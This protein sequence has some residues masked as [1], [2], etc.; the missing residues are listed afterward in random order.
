MMTK[1]LD[2]RSVLVQDRMYW[3]GDYRGA[4]DN[5]GHQLS[6]D[7]FPA[8]FVGWYV[9]ARGIEYARFENCFYFMCPGCRHFIDGIN[10]YLDGLR[11][12][13]FSLFAKVAA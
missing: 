3:L 2:P 12:N 6:H 4:C 9:D 7:W 11:A 8:V 13:Q 5:C 10:N 1:V